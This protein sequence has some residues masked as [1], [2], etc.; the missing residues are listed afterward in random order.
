MQSML[1][2]KDV[3]CVVSSISLSYYVTTLILFIICKPVL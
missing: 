3:V 2:K 1:I